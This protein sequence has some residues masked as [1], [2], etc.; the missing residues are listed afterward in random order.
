MSSEDE[1]ESSFDQQAEEAEQS[2]LREFVDFLRT[3]KKWWLTPILIGII[4]LTFAVAVSL[5]PAAPFIYTLF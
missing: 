5:S 3:N 1:S 2:L 4:L